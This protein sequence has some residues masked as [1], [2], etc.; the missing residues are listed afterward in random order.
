MFK[1][2]LFTTTLIGAFGTALLAGG[3]GGPLDQAVEAR[4]AQMK[5]YSYNLGI[6]GN[7]AK[8]SAEYD[9]ALAQ[10]AA[11]NLS[12]LARLDQSG[13]WVQGT[14]SDAM[15]TSRALPALWTD[16]GIGEKAAVFGF[17]VAG[18]EQ[19][20]GQGLDELKG[21]MGALGGACAGCHKAYR[22]SR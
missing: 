4:Q 5:L 1:K 13:F 11:K 2:V 17:A 22:K 8:G 15:E 7:M 16:D 19:A 21:A 14:D 6:L 9:A 3:H 12:A 10:A 18:M 20:A